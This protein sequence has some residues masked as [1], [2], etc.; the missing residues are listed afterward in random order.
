MARRT[1]RKDEDTNMANEKVGVVLSGCGHYDGAEIR[2]AVFALLALDEHH[3]HAAV[4]GPQRGRRCTSS[5]TSP[6]QAGGT[7][8]VLT[9]SARVARGDIRDL[10]SVQAEELDALVFPGGFGVAKNLCDFAVKGA[11]CSVH[12]EVAR[13]VREM[14]AARKPLGF[15]CISPAHGRRHLPRG[16]R[17]RAC[18]SPSA[19]RTRAP[20][21]PSRPWAPCT[22]RVPPRRGACG[23][24]P[25]RR[26]RR[27]PTCTARRASAR[28][29]AVSP[30]SSG[31]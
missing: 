18:S 17:R 13:L 1:A 14:Y 25:P 3:A 19:M 4:H 10:A 16:R 27:R 21:A 11:D 31:G 7:R 28:S 26:E 12:P 9:E 23:R 29:A 20:P 22:S 24:G 30:S 6:A 5:T 2:E 15:A 8:N